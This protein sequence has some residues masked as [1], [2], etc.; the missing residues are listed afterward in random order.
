[1]VVLGVNEL[2]SRDDDGCGQRGDRKN[3]KVKK[4]NQNHNE[5]R[6]LDSYSQQVTE[7]FP[8]SY[9]VRT[10]IPYNR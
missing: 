5:K 2:P 9:E 1:M 6:L 8:R 4:N 7:T 10:V 3:S